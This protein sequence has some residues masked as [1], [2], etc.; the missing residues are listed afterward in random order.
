MLFNLS[1]CSILIGFDYRGK[2]LA[3]VIEEFLSAQLES[4]IPKVFEYFFRK[5]LCIVQIVV[6]G[7]VYAKAFIPPTLHNLD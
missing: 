3:A 7:E 2:T 6:R 1:L 5:A 4:I